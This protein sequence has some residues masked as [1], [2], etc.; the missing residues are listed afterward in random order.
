MISNPELIHYVCIAKSTTI[1]AQ[2]N[3]TKDPKIEAL[4][5]QC[6]AQTPPNHSLFSH[7]LNDRTY[8]FLIEPPFVYFAIFDTELLK[9]QTL[10]LLNK[11][12]FAFRQFLLDS[13]ILADS[14]D[15]QPLCFQSKFDSI[16]RDML[17]FDSESSVNS[18]GGTI[19][20]GD[21]GNPSVDSVKGKRSAT[22]PLLGKPPEGLKKKKRVVGSDSNGGIEGKDG[23]SENKVVDVCDSEV[24]VCSNRDF[25]LGV[26][27]GMVN[28][29]HRQK[30]KHIWKKHVWVVLMLD[31][32]VC[33]V[34]F[35]IWLWVCSGFKCMA[36]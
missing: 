27:K 16:L 22:V 33:A 36:Y 14:D 5:S 6:I 35:V 11:I 1:L 24:Y 13:Q 7:T 18:K 2:Y 28:D 8:T 31:V 15:F 21:C 25:S 3:T 32:F 9:S 10:N 19:I 23:N 4:A 12:N 20:N 34:L 17:D 30:A 29:H 26:P